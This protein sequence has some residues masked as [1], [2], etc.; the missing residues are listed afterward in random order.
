M[1]QLYIS[2]DREN[3]RYAGWLDD[4]YETNYWKFIDIWRPKNKFELWWVT[5]GSYSYSE[6]QDRHNVK[7]WEPWEG[8]SSVLMP[9]TYS[10]EIRK[11]YAKKKKKIN[12]VYKRF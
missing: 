11:S 3:G 9:F 12:G 6:H 4:N 7:R 1:S 10:R 2:P 5:H 8:T